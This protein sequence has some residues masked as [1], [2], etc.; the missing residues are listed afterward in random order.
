MLIFE[1]DPTLYFI[2]DFFL[3]YWF[4]ILILLLAPMFRL[5]FEVASVGLSE[6]IN[7]ELPTFFGIC[8]CDSLN[9]SQA[10]GIYQVN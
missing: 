4:L 8:F 7:Y 2:V 6:L 9:D 1:G 10:L 5:L 3:D